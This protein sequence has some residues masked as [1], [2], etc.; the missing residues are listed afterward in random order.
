MLNHAVIYL[1]VTSPWRLMVVTVGNRRYFFYQRLGQLR[2][3]DC[4]LDYIEFSDDEIG[5][6]EFRLIVSEL[7]Q[8]G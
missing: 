8:S 4:P 5:V 2:R 7:S 3:V 6:L 1:G